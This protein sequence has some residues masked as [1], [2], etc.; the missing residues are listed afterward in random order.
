MRK[1]FRTAG[2]PD[3][4]DELDISKAIDKH[5]SSLLW[6]ECNTF[7]RNILISS[8]GGEG[9]AKENDV[10][11]NR[12]GATPFLSSMLD[13]TRKKGENHRRRESNKEVN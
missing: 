8:G 2:G 13:Q 3:W 11:W 9:V 7:F 4:I 5:I 6:D 10:R 1:T 12:R